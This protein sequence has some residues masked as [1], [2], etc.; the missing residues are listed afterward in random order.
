MSNEKHRLYITNSEGKVDIYEAD[1]VNNPTKNGVPFEAIPNP[2]NFDRKLPSKVMWSSPIINA[3]EGAE[4]E[5]E[6]NWNA[7]TDQRFE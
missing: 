6:L 3:N 2:N 7:T 4:D 5:S 1:G